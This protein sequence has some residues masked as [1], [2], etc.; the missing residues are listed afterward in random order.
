MLAVG[1]DTDK[2]VAAGEEEV[3]AAVDEVEENVPVQSIGGRSH[4]RRT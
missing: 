3:V 1:L 4:S 2:G